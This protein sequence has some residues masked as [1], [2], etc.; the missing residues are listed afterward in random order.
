MPGGDHLHVPYADLARPPITLWEHRHAVRVLRVEGHKTIDEQA[1]FAAIAA[2]RRVVADAYAE[3]RPPVHTLVP[4]RPTDWIG[5]ETLDLGEL[6][7]VLEPAAGEWLATEAAGVGGT[8]A[9]ATA[10]ALDWVRMVRAA[11]SAAPHEGGAST[12]IWSSIPLV[13]HAV[14]HELEDWEEQQLE[15][16]LD[17][18]ATAKQACIKAGA[19]YNWGS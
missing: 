2:Q 18:L 7:A 4:G 1:I 16:A 3:S 10:L 12:G 5:C 9:T 11:G 8:F 19:I 14:R 6:L 15:R 17:A 13:D